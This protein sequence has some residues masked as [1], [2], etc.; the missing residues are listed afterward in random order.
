MSKYEDNVF[1]L[2]QK[3][4]KT[5]GYANFYFIY[6]YLNRNEK[7][8]SASLLKKI[9]FNLKRKGYVVEVSDFN[10]KVV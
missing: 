6:N 8:L 1:K 9:I 5:Y 2:I 7:M 4:E 10:Y 3:L